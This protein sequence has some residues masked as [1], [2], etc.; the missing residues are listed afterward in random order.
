MLC[1][2]DGVLTGA[3]AGKVQCKLIGEGA[4]GPITFKG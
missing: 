4:N 1:A 2:I 3:N